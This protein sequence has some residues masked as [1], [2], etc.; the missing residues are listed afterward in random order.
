M[1]PPPRCCRATWSRS[2]PAAAAHVLVRLP[3]C[4]WDFALGYLCADQRRDRVTGS[5]SR[6]LARP[7]LTTG[8]AFCPWLCASR[9]GSSDLCRR[10]YDRYARRTSTSPNSEPSFNS[11][12]LPLLNAGTPR[13]VLVGVPWLPSDRMLV[14][15]LPASTSIVPAAHFA[16]QRSCCRA[17]DHIALGAVVSLAVCQSGAR[18]FAQYAAGAAVVL[19][20]LFRWRG[21]LAS[22]VSGRQRPADAAGVN[23]YELIP[24]LSIGNLMSSASSAGGRSAFSR[25]TAAFSLRPILPFTLAEQYRLAGMSNRRYVLLDGVGACPMLRTARWPRGLPTRIGFA[26]RSE[27]AALN[28]IR[29]GEITTA[30]DGRRDRGRVF[31]AAPACGRDSL[32]RRV[33]PLP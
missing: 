3:P 4:F 28:A 12:A 23:T 16:E 11:L 10:D 2:R 9:N 19:C 27:T 25:S 21:A 7:K 17:F 29:T 33:A 22:T 6:A 30:R 14:I 8:T 32:R 1:L 15:L 31:A 18:R 26:R 20:W 5:C 24:A 13:C